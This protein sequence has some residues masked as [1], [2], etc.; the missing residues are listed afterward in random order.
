[1]KTLKISG[2]SRRLFIKNLGTASMVP[3]LAGF[4]TA[5]DAGSKLEA[6]KSK[7]VLYPRP[8]DIAAS[9]RYAVEV[10][11]QE[12][13]V[14]S[15]TSPELATY[16]SGHTASWTS[17]DMTGAIEIRV[18][19]NGRP[20]NMA[21]V[22]PG[23]AGIVPKVIDG[24]LVIRLD[25][26]RKLAVECDRD[27]TDVLFIFANE[28]ETDIPSP[29]RK[30]VVRFGPGVHEIGKDYQ[31]EPGKTYYL[32]AGAF[33]KGTFSGGGDG[34]RIMGR[35]V[36]SGADYKWPGP[37]TYGPGGH[38]GR[39]DLV[40]LEG[41]KLELSGITLVDSP[42]YVVLARGKDCR[43]SNLKILAW[44]DNTDSISTG[45]GARI[46]N[47]FIR[48][49]DDV[50]KTFR[51]DTRI[52]R[53]VVWCDK[54]AA[55]NLSWKVPQDCGGSVVRDCDVIHHKPFEDKLHRWTGAVFRSWFGGGGHIHDILFEDIR[56][57]GQSPRLISI[58]FERNKW[59]RQSGE[60]GSFSKLHFRNIT[61][62][63]PFLFHSQLLGH[64]AA[65]TI[66]DVVFENLRIGGELIRSAGQMNLKTNEFVRNLS[67]IV[68]DV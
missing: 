37:D 2:L 22:R 34:T 10:D 29:D 6:Q 18:R 20:I 40:R 16:T 59:S 49:A 17:F 3:F 13:F 65:H 1:M 46:D 21:T 54:G 27:L 61:A 15:T 58:H 14:Y 68:T 60:W 67:F 30:D 55:F 52:S 36:L 48:V 50:F 62:T 51:T 57:E 47:C 43:F 9:D 25:R 32:A 56:I 35:G 12:S 44:Y 23:S 64:D 19:R 41:D 45:S 5:N 53:C 28:P 26:P 38:P 11:G 4:S 39:V 66:D 63:G 24:E 31:L 8:A 33:V 42:Y 7:A